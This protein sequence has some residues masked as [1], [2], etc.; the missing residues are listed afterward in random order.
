MIADD[1][2]KKIILQFLN[3]GESEG[4]KVKK[5]QPFGKCTAIAIGHNNMCG[6]L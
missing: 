2:H 5:M 6:F 3:H 1:F 4:L